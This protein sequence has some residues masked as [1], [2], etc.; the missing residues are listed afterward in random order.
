[1]FKECNHMTSPLNTSHPTEIYIKHKLQNLKY[2]L[3]RKNSDTMIII[4][5]TECQN[6]ELVMNNLNYEIIYSIEA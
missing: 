2:I 3:F 4:V 6:D 1:M 5:L